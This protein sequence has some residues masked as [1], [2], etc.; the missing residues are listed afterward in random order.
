M[1]SLFLHLCKYSGL[2]LLSNYLLRKKLLI[3]CYHGFEINNESQFRPQLFIK[4]DTFEHR[5]KLLNRKSSYI[6]SLDQAVQALESDNLPDNSVV[7]TIDD[8]FYSVLS[9]A[10]PLLRQYDFPA[11]LYLTTMDMQKGQPILHLLIGYMIATTTIKTVDSNQ[12]QWGS[13]EQI[14]LSFPQNKKKFTDVCLSYAEQIESF[15]ELEQFYKELGNLLEIDYENV[16]DSRL[17]TLMSESEVSM[18]ASKGLDIQLHTHTH[19][20]PQNDAEKASHEIRKNRQI[21]EKLTSGP[22]VHFCYPSGQWSTLHWPVLKE[23]GI[24]SATTCLPGLNDSNVN[25]LALNRFLDG[26]DIPD[27]VFESELYRFN[28]LLRKLK[29]TFK[30]RPISTTNI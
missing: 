24:K 13:D 25:L 28:E 4:K 18:L 27:I 9:I 7:I 21:L 3:L 6:V 10:F 20:F 17:V 30:R 15:E 19:Q 16:R 5:L 1:K 26:E 12:Y 22:L 14:D 23:T 11:T 29:N 2:F 8:G